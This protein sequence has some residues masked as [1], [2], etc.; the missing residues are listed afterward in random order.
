MRHLPGR[1][2]LAGLALVLA[3]CNAT[4]KSPTGPGGPPAGSLQLWSDPGTWPSGQVP[5]AGDSVVIPAGLR[6]RLDTS[7]PALHSLTIA[8]DLV[9]GDNDITLT[10]GWILV[11]GLLQAGTKRSPYARQAFIQLSF[12]SSTGEPVTPATMQRDDAVALQITGTGGGTTH[13]SMTAIPDR[14]YSVQ[15]T[16][17]TP[18]SPNFY[19]NSANAGDMV[20]LAVPYVS[21]PSQIIRDYYGGNPMS[22]AAS[23]AALETS[24]AGDRY[25]YDAGTTTLY[26]KFV[27]MP[28]RDWATLFVRP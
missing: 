5:V 14:A 28:G 22:A 24:T 3:A 4:D 21:A 8:G 26:L 9:F 12:I 1:Q 25:Y 17:A 11:D 23:T 7:P 6:V 15:W 18:R 20:S 19:L 27:V 2:G 16:A 13:G 10:T